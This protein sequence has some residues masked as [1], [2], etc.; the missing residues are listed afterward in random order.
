MYHARIGVAVL[1][2]LVV[3]A[4]ALYVGRGF[5]R[6]YSRVPPVPS[7]TI[8]HRD[9]AYVTNGHPRQKLDLYLPEG[10][11]NPALMIL[12]HGGGFTEGD[13]R[14]EDVAQ[15][16]T[17][18]YAV[19]SLN[20]RLAQDAIFPAQIEDCKAA[21]RWLRANAKNY[22]YDPDRFG[23]RGSSAGGYLVTMLGTTG[24]TTKFD[25]GENL[26]A[27]SRVQAVADRYGPIDFLQMDAHQIPGGAPVNTPDSPISKLIGG[28][29]E[30]NKEKAENANPLNYVT[31]D[32]PPFIIVH[33]DSDPLVP[34]HQSELLADALE[35]AGVPAT[36]YTVKGG[37]HGGIDDPGAGAAVREFFARYL[38]SNRD[39]R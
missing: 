12:I 27:S 25:V 4:L 9:L 3:L 38:R 22:G 34:H 1:L 26:S 28:N 36:L 8:V 35:R 31:K 33:G 5:L 20:Y 2:A 6:R 29:L 23:A 15:W 7:G 13:K 30:D 19:A 18:G 16:L 21:V 39:G 24:S 11:E 37:G 14:E 10:A 32:C 17:Q